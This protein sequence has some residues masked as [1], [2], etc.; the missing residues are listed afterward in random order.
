M[1]AHG[2]LGMPSLVLKQVGLSKSVDQG[3][4]PGVKRSTDLGV[5]CLTRLQ[6]PRQI[7]RPYAWACC[8]GMICEIMILEFAFDLFFVDFFLV[9]HILEIFTLGVKNQ[10]KISHADMMF[11][12]IQHC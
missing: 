6:V 2:E 8:R 10:Q 9:C 5:N 1:K 11:T 3:W 12:Q 7:Q 4:S